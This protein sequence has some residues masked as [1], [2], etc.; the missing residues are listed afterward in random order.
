MISLPAD[1]VEVIA[2]STQHKSSWFEPLWGAFSAK[3][4]V[5]VGIPVSSPS[6]K[7]KNKKSTH[8]MLLCGSVCAW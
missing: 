1:V 8:L 4:R 2:V 7:Q 6:Q 3:L 5:L